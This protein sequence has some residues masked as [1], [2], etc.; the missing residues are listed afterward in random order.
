MDFYSISISI[1]NNQYILK[2]LFINE[3]V[4]YLTISEPSTTYF[5]VKLGKYLT[6]NGNIWFLNRWSDYKVVHDWIT[7][8]TTTRFLSVQ[9]IIASLSPTISVD[10]DTNYPSNISGSSIEPH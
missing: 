7:P 8:S 5:L 9:I 6:K 10:I 4:S 3:S 2:I 1:N